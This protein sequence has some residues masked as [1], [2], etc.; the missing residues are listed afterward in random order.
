MKTFGQILIVIFLFSA[1]A[2]LAQEQPNQAQ[3]N[4]KPAPQ[5]GDDPHAFRDPF[6]PYEAEEG[7]LKNQITPL[8][9][10]DLVDLKVVGIIWSNIEPKAMVVDPK[11]MTHFVKKKTKMGRGEGYVA[12][13]RD[14]EVVVVEPYEEGGQTFY[15]TRILPLVK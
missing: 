14:G 8:Q 12:L 10:Y 15:N 3:P 4:P 7:G 13:I 2:L 6:Q 1:N 9:K 5:A 11:G